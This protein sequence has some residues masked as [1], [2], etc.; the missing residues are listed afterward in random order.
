LPV[1]IETFTLAPK[2]SLPKYVDRKL[3][4]KGK[5][6]ATREQFFQTRQER[7]NRYFSE[8]FK[9]SKVS[10]I[11]KGLVSV[12]E[13]AREYEVTRTAI[14]KWIYKYSAMKKKKERLVLETDSDTRK[15]REMKEKIKELERI[16]GQKQIL[17]DFQG[18]VIEMA[19]EEYK[20]DIKKKYGEEPSS[21]T[22]TTESNTV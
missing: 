5:H 2:R 14:Y 15:L 10:D 19:E 16:I 20:V 18:K 17:I 12:S 4:K 6:M 3:I 11:E 21:G 13:L 1:V 9:R 8:S 7:Q 22:G